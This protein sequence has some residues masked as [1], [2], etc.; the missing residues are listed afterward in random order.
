[1]GRDHTAMGRGCAETACAGER[2]EEE[3]LHDL[4]G[5]ILQHPSH[6]RLQSVTVLLEEVGSF[7]RHLEKRG[8]GGGQR[9]GGQRGREGKGQGDKEREVEGERSRRG[10]R[11]EGDGGEELNTYVCAKAPDIPLKSMMAYTACVV[12]DREGGTSIL[13]TLVIR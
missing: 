5:G 10:G 9:E 13:G 1:M 4:V 12:G 2:R 3:Q 7:V 8:K 6:L 11:V